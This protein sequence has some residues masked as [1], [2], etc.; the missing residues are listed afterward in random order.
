MVKL[1]IVLMALVSVALVSLLTWSICTQYRDAGCEHLRIR[2]RLEVKV[3]VVRLDEPSMTV[4][5]TGT[6]A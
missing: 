6:S 2:R 4:R 1:D 3:R 5:D